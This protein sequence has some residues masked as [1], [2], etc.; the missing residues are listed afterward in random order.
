MCSDNMVEVWLFLTLEFEIGVGEAMQVKH[1]QAIALFQD[2][3][4]AGADKWS[5]ARCLAKLALIRDDDSLEADGE[6]NQTLL[7][8][9]RAT[10]TEF[11]IVADD[12][13]EDADEA[14][15]AKK[16][17]AKAEPEPEADTDDEDVPAPKAK[18]KA[19]VEPEA[20]TDADTDD[21]DV[22]APPKAKKKAKAEP[23][24]DD[25][26]DVPA[27]AK[28]K[29]KAEPEA[30]TDTD[31]ED[32]PAKAPKAKKKA[33]KNGEQRPGVIA[34]IV[35][36]L[37]KATEKHP[38]TKAKILEALVSKFPDREEESMAKTVNVQLSYHLKT[39][40]GLS[41]QRNDNGYWLDSE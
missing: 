15:K 23:E 19:K 36:C 26:E 22:P 31:D 30:D 17:A 20:D 29:A 35:E 4:W 14:P 10:K 5:E 1:S 3:G 6:E 13:D 34:S 9:V 37:K 39:Y 7:D 12:T 33:K 40:K 24:V 32:V 28:K 21:E 38:I 27:K 18:K 2:L 8:K 25:D 41:V 16:K 11:E